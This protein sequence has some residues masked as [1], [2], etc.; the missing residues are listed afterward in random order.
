MS[1]E[2]WQLGWVVMIVITAVGALVVFLSLEWD[3]FKET[4]IIR[5]GKGDGGT[6]NT[7][8]LL[9]LSLIL[10]LAFVLLVAWILTLFIKD[11]ATFTFFLI[12]ITFAAL[13]GLVTY[14]NR[15][16]DSSG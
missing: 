13:Y 8:L 12:T 5:S 6:L 11:I 16:A 1:E 10:S 7:L 2:P 3:S 9:V 4:K 14:L 15:S